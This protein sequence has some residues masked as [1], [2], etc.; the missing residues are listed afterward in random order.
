MKS[1][2][3]PIS[4]MELNKVIKKLGKVNKER[5]MIEHIMMKMRT[6]LQAKKQLERGILRCEGA[7]STLEVLLKEFRHEL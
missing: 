1:K 6:T 5:V 4:K 3:K 2:Q 7:I